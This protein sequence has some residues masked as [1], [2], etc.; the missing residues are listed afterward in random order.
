[1]SAVPQQL[2]ASLAPMRVLV[3]GKI[4]SSRMHERNRLT[5]LIAPAP[6]AYSHP[7]TIEVRSRQQLGQVG[8]EVRVTCSLRGYM[9]RFDFKDRQTGELKR[10]E[11]C[12]HSLDAVE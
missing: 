11:R 8:E 4:V 1:M 5:V 12:E 6:D 10:G 2:A 3:A 9:R 7:S